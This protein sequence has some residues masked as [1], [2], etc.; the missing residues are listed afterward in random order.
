M[1]YSTL[2]ALSIPKATS[3]LPQTVKSSTP[4]QRARITNGIFRI[5]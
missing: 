4:K 3:E 1:N 5:L 2:D